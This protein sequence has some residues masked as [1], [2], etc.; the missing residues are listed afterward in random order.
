MFYRFKSGNGYIIGVKGVGPLLLE[1]KSSAL[2]L[3]Y[4]PNP[5]I[6]LACSLMVEHTTHNGSVEGSSPSRPKLIRLEGDLNPY[7]WFC[8]PTHYRYAIQ[9]FVHIL[10]YI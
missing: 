2:P 3:G 4:T 6:V 8:R 1:S 7:I 5:K 10:H 9:S